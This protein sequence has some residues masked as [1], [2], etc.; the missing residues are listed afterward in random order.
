MAFAQQGRGGNITLNTRAFFGQDYRPGSPPPWDGN[1]RVDINASGT[2]A[3]VITLPDTSF[4]QNGLTSFSQVLVDSSKLLANSCIVRRNR[5]TGSTFFITGSGGLPYRPGDLPLAAFPMGEV[6]NVAADAVTD[7][8]VSA[9][10]ND[11]TDKRSSSS[12]SSVSNPL[13]TSSASTPRPWKIGDPIVEP[14]GVYQLPNGE[15]VMSRECP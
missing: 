6:R 1:G 3:G 2:V 5:E 13:P 8:G 7:F 10:S 12:A 9:Q 4:I 14:Q 11:G 15:L